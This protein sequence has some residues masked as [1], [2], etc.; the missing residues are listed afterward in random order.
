MVN[1]CHNPSLVKPDESPNGNTI[2]HIYS[3]GEITI[4]KG[5]WAYSRRIEFPLYYSLGLQL[6]REKFPSK[7]LSHGYAIVTKHDA[8][9]IRNAMIKLL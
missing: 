9:M 7:T 3:D 1:R 8:T 2:Y 4:Q 5:E 6:D